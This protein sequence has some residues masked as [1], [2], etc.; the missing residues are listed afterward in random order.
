MRGLLD[1][2]TTYEYGISSSGVA[3]LVMDPE[4]AIDLCTTTMSPPLVGAYWMYGFLR[5]VLDI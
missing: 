4:K 5:H 2:V 3:I 1:I